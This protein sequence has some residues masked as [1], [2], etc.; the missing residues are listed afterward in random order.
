MSEE[1][2]QGIFIDKHKMNNMDM[3]RIVV[4][5]PAIKTI[6]K[7]TRLSLQ[8]QEDAVNALVDRTPDWMELGEDEDTTEALQIAKIKTV[9]TQETVVAYLQE[10]EV[11]RDKV[12]TL[13][14]GIDEEGSIVVYAYYTN[15]N[16][17]QRRAMEKAYSEDDKIAL[18]EA[19]NQLG[20]EKIVDLAAKKIEKLKEEGKD[21]RGRKLH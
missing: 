16:R 7:V 20:S 3:E 14:L 18:V 12:D 17:E 13:E 2:I 15:L 5:D 8:A 19:F 10:Q 6:L 9:L 4:S 21:F 1:L 11:I